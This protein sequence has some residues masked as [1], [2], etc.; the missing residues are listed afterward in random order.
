MPTL[1]DALADLPGQTLR[2]RT[3]LVASFIPGSVTLTLDEEAIPDV[4]YLASYSPTVG[5]V[6]HVLQVPGQL[7]VLGRAA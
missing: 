2:L 5:D 3:A 6:V 7:L 4:A 1:V